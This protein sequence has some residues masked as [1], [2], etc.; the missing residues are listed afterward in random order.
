MNIYIY[1][2]MFTSREL[3][4]TKRCLSLHLLVPLGAL[5]LNPWNIYTYSSF[6]AIGEEIVPGGL[7]GRALTWTLRGLHLIPTWGKSIFSLKWIYDEYLHLL[8]PNMFGFANDILIAG[9]NNIG[10]GHNHTID[11]VLRICRQANLKLNKDQ[12]LFWC[13]S[14]PFFGEI[15]SCQ[16]LVWSQEKYRLW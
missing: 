5:Q 1:Y 13:T 8:L 7:V 6:W 16:G 10:R 15:I 12:C 14:I 9:F 2:C 4:F 11:E 3:N